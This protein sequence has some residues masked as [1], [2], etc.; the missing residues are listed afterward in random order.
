MNIAYI[1][2]KHWLR[3]DAAQSYWRMLFAGMPG[4]GIN[5][6]GRT[7]AEQEIMYARY[8]RG[9]LKATAARPGTSRH[10][11]GVALDL[12]GAAQSWVR[13]N[14][15]E[16]GWVKDRVPRELWHMEYFPALD[17][18]KNSIPAPADRA[19]D[20][21]HSPAIMEPEMTYYKALSNSY[22]GTILK[23]YV[24]VQSGNDPVRLVSN[25]EYEGMVLPLSVEKP[26]RV[27]V[28]SWSGDDI[29]ILAALVGIAETARLTVRPQ[30]G[31]GKRLT[32]PGRLTGRVKFP[33]ADDYQGDW[34]YPRATKDGV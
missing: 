33:G 2:S 11:S 27:R 7:R 22:D 31:L 6:A 14:G 15:L 34:H 8:L 4:G 3:E 24:Y 10:E 12:S 20:P 29:L 1:S 19:P 5:D 21:V 28:V 16:F 32:G 9:E 13:A 18:R 30:T 17:M 23:D 25:L 26:P